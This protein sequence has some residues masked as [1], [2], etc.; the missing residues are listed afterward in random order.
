MACR[1]PGTGRWLAE[2]EAGA[3]AAWD[4]PPPPPALPRSPGLGPEGPPGRAGP[5]SRFSHPGGLPGRPLPPGRRTG[6]PPGCPSFGCPGAPG[7][8]QARPGYPP[9]HP[10]TPEAHCRS[11]TPP[12]GRSGPGYPGCPPGIVPA[13]CPPRH[14]AHTGSAPPGCR[15][16]RQQPPGAAPAAGGYRISVVSRF[17]SSSDSPSEGCFLPVCSSTAKK[18]ISTGSAIRGAASMGSI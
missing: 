13:P 8:W 10:R 15:G 18:M 3:F 1:E 2:P 7:P 12:P 14:A 17:S 4:K 5:Y 16:S 6:H 9:G 11:Q